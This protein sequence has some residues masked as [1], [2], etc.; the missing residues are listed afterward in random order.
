MKHSWFACV[1]WDKVLQKRVKPPF[2]P[3][4]SSPFDLRYFDSKFT[5]QPIEVTPRLFERKTPLLYSCI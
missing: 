5:E 2:T 4:L 1:N 3:K